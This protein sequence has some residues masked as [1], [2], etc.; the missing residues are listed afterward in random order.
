MDIVIKQ[1][2]VTCFKG[3]VVFCVRCKFLEIRGLTL[4][5]RDFPGINSFSSVYWPCYGGIPGVKFNTLFLA[6]A[7][8][9]M[10]LS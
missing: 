10:N 1:A 4:E 6:L 2:Q 7:L 5:L 8:R 9:T 3:V